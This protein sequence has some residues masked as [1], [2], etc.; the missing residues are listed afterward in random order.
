MILKNVL[1]HNLLCWGCGC[2]SH[3]SSPLLLNPDVSCHVGTS[4]QARQSAQHV[5]QGVP[6]LHRS[7]NPGL[8]EYST[9]TP[10]TWEECSY[11]CNSKCFGGAKNVELAVVGRALL[12]GVCSSQTDTSLV[13]W[14]LLSPVSCLMLC[15]HM[16]VF[17]VPDPKVGEEICVYLR[18]KTGI[19][20]TDQDIISYC[21]DKVRDSPLTERTASSQNIVV[22]NCQLTAW[23]WLDR[24][25]R[26]S[27]AQQI[28]SPRNLVNC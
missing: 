21:R 15:Y 11:L 26:H 2:S 6:I 22:L 17:G 20:L 18:L 27:V 4:Q 3:R 14:M 5:S 13:A 24:P 23:H 28:G 16:Q 8:P 7:L 19:T 25:S 12:E 1:H 10:L 9:A